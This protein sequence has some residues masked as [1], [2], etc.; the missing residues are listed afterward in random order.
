MT[1]T[2]TRLVPYGEA[3][4]RFSLVDD[5]PRDIESMHTVIVRMITSGG[6]R[7]HSLKGDV[8]TSLIV[9]RQNG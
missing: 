1:D 9:E 3:T 4:D 2:R 5:Q 6:Y 8:P 7:N